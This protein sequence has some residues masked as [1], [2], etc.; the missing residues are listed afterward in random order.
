MIF[1]DD[2]SKAF[3]AVKTNKQT[4]QE[5]Y[6]SDVGFISLKSC[7]S[8]Q[9]C[10]HY[11]IWNQQLL[12]MLFNSLSP[13]SGAPCSKII[14]RLPTQDSQVRHR[15]FHSALKAIRLYRTNSDC[16]NHEKSSS[17]VV[18][19]VDLP[20]K[21]CD[22]KYTEL[23]LYLSLSLSDGAQWFSCTSGFVHGT[24]ADPHKLTCDTF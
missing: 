5:L 24:F 3:S 11:V 10:C 18:D 19:C 8:C 17:S 23:S 4:N 1:K 9:N 16:V 2:D 13:S 21:M 6:D 12:I 22:Q 15:C 20:G 7:P 14:S